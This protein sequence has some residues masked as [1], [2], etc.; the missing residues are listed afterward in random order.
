MVLRAINRNE[1]QNPDPCDV[2]DT[3]PVCGGNMEEVYSRPHQMVCACQD[4]QT[5]ITVPGVAWDIAR[6]KN[7]TRVPLKK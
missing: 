6:V 7:K 2:L 1:P 3:C 5:T 4:C